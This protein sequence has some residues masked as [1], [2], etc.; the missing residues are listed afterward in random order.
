MLPKLKIAVVGSYRAF[1]C[2]VK[3]VVENINI[4]EACNRPTRNRL[5]IEGVTFFAVM[6]TRHVRGMIFNGY[7]L[8]HDAYRLPE[9][10]EIMDYLRAGLRPIR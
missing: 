10:N 9:L 5:D 1:D 6:D 7:I 4:T 8:G 2:F 3:H